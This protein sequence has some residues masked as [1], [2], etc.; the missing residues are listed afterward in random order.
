M[1]GLI[2][3]SLGAISAP[4]NRVLEVG[5]INRAEQASFM[6]DDPHPF[7]RT[8]NQEPKH[9]KALQNCPAVVEYEARHFVVTCPIDLNI[10]LAKDKEERLGIRDLDGQQSAIGS[11]QLSKI[12]TVNGPGQWRHPGRPL[13]QILTPYYFVADEVCWM[14]Q[15]PPYLSYRDPP[16]PGT[17]VGGRL[18]IHIWP[19]AMI[20][21]F[22]WCDP[23]KPLHLKRGEPWFLLRFE[24]DN[25]RRQVRLVEAEWTAE[26][27]QFSKG[28]DAVTNFQR[29][30]WSLFK[31]AARRRPEKLVKKVNRGKPSFADES[32]RNF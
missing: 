15:L 17:L 25:P 1:L 29:R 13:I 30:T 10:A 9:A 5:W 24:T 21:A 31:I 32:D 3:Q 19:R 23:S 18:P 11:R 2:K 12:L 20:W 27:D 22:E 28:A 26:L 4:S 6:W 16:W 14:N 8:D 7:R